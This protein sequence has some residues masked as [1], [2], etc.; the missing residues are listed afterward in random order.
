V[1]GIVTKR[2]ALAIM[3]LLT[4]RKTSS[5]SDYSSNACEFSRSSV[6]QVYGVKSRLW[7]EI[8]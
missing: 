4:S 3:M 8:S 6:S 5:K 2:I 1:A 7:N